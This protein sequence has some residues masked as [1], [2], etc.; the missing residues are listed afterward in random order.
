MRAGGCSIVIFDLDGTL[1]H[2]DDAMINAFS[3]AYRQTVGPGM[4]PIAELRRHL[5]KPIPTIAHELGLPE[6]FASAYAAASYRFA[7]L[8]YA[9]AGIRET[10]DALKRSSVRLAVATGRDNAR[11]RFILAHVGLLGLFDRVFG[12]DDVAEGKPA[13][14]IV[15][16]AIA[17]LEG[18]R[19]ATLMV[20]DSAADLACARA[21]GVFTVAA[22]W[23][24]SA[25]A[26]D[27]LGA[28]TVL[29]HPF[30]IV[31]LVRNRAAGSVRSG[32]ALP[33]GCDAPGLDAP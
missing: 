31:D 14:D 13:P 6:S 5:G 15:E 2:N 1:V 24:P 11:A 7:H 4:P 29:D 33:D 30:G 26:T 16:R 27:F 32:H 20:G 3:A 21:A 19:Q 10:L 8:A 9:Y 23:N 12:F 28:D 18:D 17:E 22:G 25:R